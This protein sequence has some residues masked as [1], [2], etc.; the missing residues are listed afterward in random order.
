VLKLWQ[1]I[2]AIIVAHVDGLVI[3]WAGRM[4]QKAT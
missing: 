2:K 4:K 1:W 3:Y